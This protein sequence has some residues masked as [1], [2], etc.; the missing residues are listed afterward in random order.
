MA[1]VVG[2][3]KAAKFLFAEMRRELGYEKKNETTSMGRGVENPS[4]KGSARC[5]ETMTSPAAITDFG[6]SKWAERLVL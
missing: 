3:G 1:V 2:W 6:R 4:K 5:T